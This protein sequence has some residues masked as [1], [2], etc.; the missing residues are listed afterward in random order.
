M[1]R[2]FVSLGNGSGFIELQSWLWMVNCY[3]RNSQSL[4]RKSLSFTGVYS[5]EKVVSLW[6]TSKD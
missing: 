3:I 5:V 2:K 6:N 1:G 4:L